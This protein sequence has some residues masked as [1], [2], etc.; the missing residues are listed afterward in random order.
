[1]NRIVFICRRYCPGEAW[2]NRL[3]AYARG[4]AEHGV[5][6]C[7]LFIITDNKR[8]PYNIDI[9]GVEVI[10]LWEND[11]WL[12]KI[13]RG[14]SYYFNRKKI[15]DYILDGDYCFFTDGSGLYIEEVRKSNKNIRI[16]FESTEHPMILLKSKSK[17]DNFLKSLSFVDF[18]FV[19]SRSLCNYYCQCGL[20]KSKIQVINMFVDTNRFDNLTKTTTQ[21]YIAYCGNVSYQKDGVDIL[22]QAFAR[23][24]DKHPDYKLEIYGRSVRNSISDLSKLATELGIEDSV[25]FT[26]MLPS[27]QIPSK[28]YNASIL[29][30]SRPNNLQNQNGFPTKLG[31]YLMTGNPV[32]VTNVGEISHFIVDEHNGYLAMPDDIDSFAQKLDKAVKD[33]DSKKNVGVEGRKLALSEFSYFTQTGIALNFILKNE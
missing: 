20:P 22:I 7:F 9:S 13:H 24:K 3:L 2:T 12:N 1:M 11:G 10:N 18:I 23:F 5:K 32:V 33:L 27:T 29:A 25:I 4:F 8:T 14:I 6:V 21:K 28:L 17:V 26:G 15:S 19:I 31:E 16:I 30:L